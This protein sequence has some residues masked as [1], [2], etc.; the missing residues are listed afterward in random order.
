MFWPKTVVRA[1]VPANF[2][3]RIYSAHNA[4]R[5]RFAAPCPRP[6]ASAARHESSAEPERMGDGPRARWLSTRTRERVA[7]GGATG[8]ASERER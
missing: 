6:D 1:C 2:R 5:A 4:A 8:S 3:A 7:T